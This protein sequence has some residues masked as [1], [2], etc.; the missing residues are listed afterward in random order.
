MNKETKEHEEKVVVCY[1]LAVCLNLI[2][3]KTIKSEKCRMEKM[4]FFERNLS[5]FT[6]KYAKFKFL[7]REMAA[8]KPTFKHLNP[9]KW[10][11]E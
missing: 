6:D 7:R 10:M 1:V 5:V 4:L 2:Y 8:W 11:D 3:V 9:S